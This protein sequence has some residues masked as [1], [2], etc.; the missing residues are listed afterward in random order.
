MAEEDGASFNLAWPARVFGALIGT[1][2]DRL[3][4]RWTD[5]AGLAPQP[6]GRPHHAS[7]SAGKR[8]RPRRYFSADGR[9]KLTL[10]EWCLN[11]VPRIRIR[12][13]GSC[14]T[15]PEHFQQCAEF[16]LLRN[17]GLRALA[18]TV[19][20]IPFASAP[21]CNRQPRIWRSAHLRRNYFDKTFSCVH[22]HGV[23]VSSG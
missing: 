1:G 16:P 11:M 14:Q 7:R 17:R 12:R 20:P 3:A 5:D 6:R 8:V 10:R 18:V 9:P 2:R 15:S 13:Q 22:L 19:L 4:A 23:I 21:P